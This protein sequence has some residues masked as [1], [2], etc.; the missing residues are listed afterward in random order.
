MTDADVATF[1]MDLRF[2]EAFHGTGLWSFLTEWGGG[3]D[4]FRLLHPGVT[5]FDQI[6]R[7]APGSRWLWNGDNLI[8]E[9]GGKR[10]VADWD[11]FDKDIQAELK[12][13]LMKKDEEERRKLARQ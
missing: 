9:A 7:P 1:D 11:D 5:L 6:Q 4:P 3:Q 8:L 10:F 13:I 2:R 12:P